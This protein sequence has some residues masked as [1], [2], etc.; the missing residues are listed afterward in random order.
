MSLKII[1]PIQYPDWDSFV[2]EFP[3]CSFFHT[4]SWAR[5]LHESY[6]YTPCYF[7]Q[8]NNDEMVAALPLMEIKSP[9]TGCRGVSL[10][11]TDNCPPLTRN[12]D[13]SEFL[14]QEAFQYGEKAKW[15]YVEFR[16][17]GN[18][19]ENKKIFSRFYTHTLD[20]T[21]GEQ[22]LYNNLKSTTR[23]NIK[24]ARKQEVRVHISQSADCLRE[25][26]RLN[27]I[28]R[29]KHGVPPQPDKFFQKIHEHIFQNS[30]GFVALAM[31]NQKPIAGAVYF[32]FGK[33]AMYKYGASHPDFLSL[34][35]NN[36]VMWEAIKWYT[37]HG[38]H[39]LNFGRNDLE[40]HGLLRFKRGWTPK[41]SQLKYIR[42][43]LNT[44]TFETSKNNSK[45]T[46]K[47]FKKLPI[48]LLKLI[49]RVLYKHTG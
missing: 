39:T 38:F 34:R 6:Q 14:F 27:R 40:N 35:P 3:W 32:H 1:N 33:A 28:T 24:K 12:A 4:A 42:Y 23:R 37:G 48:P 21:P 22:N 36:L 44:Q 19:S 11:F 5:V 13:N 46:W 26:C 25:F 20:L 31:V 7:A 45:H 2:M 15:K 29:K 8:Y 16:D 49:G 10:P 41:E 9:I 47:M 30:Q 43:N 17:S 18:F